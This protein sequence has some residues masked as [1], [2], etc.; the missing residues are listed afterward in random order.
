MVYTW[1]I[2]ISLNTGSVDGFQD[3]KGLA[4]IQESSKDLWRKV[5][6]TLYQVVS[7]IYVTV[8]FTINHVCILALFPMCFV[9]NNTQNWKS[10]KKVRAFITWMMS[11]GCRLGSSTPPLQTLE[12]TPLDVYPPSTSILHASTWSH[13]HDECSQAFPIYSPLLLLCQCN[14]KTEHTRPGRPV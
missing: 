7:P 14:T 12:T 6:C 3:P 1:S 11:G 2:N 8:S 5:C 13:W 4:W 9:E 10:G